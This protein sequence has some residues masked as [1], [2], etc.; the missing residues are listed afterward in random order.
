MNSLEIIG[1]LTADPELRTVNTANG[2]QLVC[3]FTVA[4]NRIVRGQ[5]I[6]EYFRV[7]LWNKQANNANEYLSKGSKVYV[8]GPVT[9]RAFQKKDGSWQAS[10]DILG[11][12]IEYLSYKSDT[13]ASQANAQPQPGY[14]EG[15]QQ[16]DYQGYYQQEQNEASQDGFM[17]APPVDDGGL[18]FG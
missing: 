18:P 11:D 16:P 13:Q 4:N 9:A 8:R 17:S 3:N 12:T 1:N 7:T 14:Q 5:K 15:Y 10:I 2:P 6:S